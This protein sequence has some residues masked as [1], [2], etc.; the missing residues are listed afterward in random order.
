MRRQPASQARQRHLEGP[1]LAGPC[2]CRL[3]P[4]DI[5]PLLPALLSQPETGRHIHFPQLVPLVR[6]QRLRAVAK[7]PGPFRWR[8]ARALWGPLRIPVRPVL[9]PN[10]TT[11]ACLFPHPQKPLARAASAGLMCAPDG[12]CILIATQGPDVDNELAQKLWQAS[13]QRHVQAN[14]CM[15]RQ[16][17]DGLV[18]AS[19][20]LLTHLSE[21]KNVA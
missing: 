6:L 1:L 4:L 10:S 14:S 19:W 16:L 17:H 13:G 18:L 15:L 7:V 9:S 20:R 11:A 8:V 5:V 21:L 2:L 12:A 3:G